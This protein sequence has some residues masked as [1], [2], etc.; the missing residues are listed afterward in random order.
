MTILNKKPYEILLILIILLSTIFCSN[1]ILRSQELNT[2]VTIVP[3]K[4]MINKIA[5][6]KISV[7]VLIPPGYSPGNYAPKPSELTKLSDA[8]IY[9]SIGVPAD[10]QNILPKIKQFNS[11][12]KVVRLDKMVS[13][14]YPDRKFTNGSRDQH[15]WLSLKRTKVMAEI[16]RDQLIKLNP[17]QAE[18]YKRNTKIYIDK[19]EKTQKEIKELLKDKKG[20]FFLVYHP[21]YGYFAE[22]FDLKMISIEEDGK[23]A[24]AKQIQKII[25][26]AREN[27][28]DKI[29]YQAEI[30][31][32]QTKAIA[33][34]IDAELIKLDP[35]AENHLEN[36]VEIAKKIAGVK[37]SE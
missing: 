10:I 13:N 23:E 37:E 3:Q 32:R 11:D 29:F 2:A 30:D 1:S 27:N 4:D 19:I 14:I 21:S 12:I 5:G 31:S 25:D 18:S 22:E 36:L 34:E 24:T 35:L 16:I 20:D 6:Q 28:I 26:F 9:F 33:E 17:D 15:I 7:T 8:K